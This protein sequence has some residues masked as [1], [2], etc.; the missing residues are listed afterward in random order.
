MSDDRLA[1]YLAGAAQPGTHALDRFT[2]RVITNLLMHYCIPWLAHCLTTY[3]EAD[4]H[5]RMLDPSFDFISDWR[6]NHADRYPKFVAGARRL[7]HRFRFDVDAITERVATSIS[8]Q[9][10]WQIYPFEYLILHSTIS[11]VKDEIYG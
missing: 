11:R 5:A 9:A 2:H 3:S 1:D 7:R 4:F 6:L 8:T 10:G